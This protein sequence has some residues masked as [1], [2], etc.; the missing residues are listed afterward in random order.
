MGKLCHRFPIMG[1]GHEEAAHSGDG[2]DVFK[3]VPSYADTP[4][5]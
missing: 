5:G 2:V 3:L 1:S 4:S